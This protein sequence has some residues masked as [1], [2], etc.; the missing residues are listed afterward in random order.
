MADGIACHDLGGG[1]EGN[2]FLVEDKS[3]CE[4]VGHAFE[5]VMG[6]DDEVT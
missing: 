5:L 2:L 6:G 3:V 4:N 1:A